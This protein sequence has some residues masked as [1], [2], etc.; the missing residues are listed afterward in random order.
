MHVLL[1]I[2][3]QKRKQRDAVLEI[4]Y[5]EAMADHQNS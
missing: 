3:T 5:K 1:D 2:K 4:A